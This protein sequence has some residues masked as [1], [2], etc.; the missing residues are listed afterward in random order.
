MKIE[1]RIKEKLGDFQRLRHGVVKEIAS[2][3]KIHRHTI[4]R[5]CRNE[6]RVVSFETLEK[7]CDWFHEIGVPRD[8]L[9]GGLLGFRR[10]ALWEAIASPGRV[11]LYLGEYWEEKPA[12]A[13]WRWVARRDS[14]VHGQMVKWLSTEGDSEIKVPEIGSVYVPFRYGSGKVRA[15]RKQLEQ[16]VD[17]ART[18][19][20]E[21][22]QGGQY[23]NILIGSQRANY[24]VELLVADL[25]GCEPFKPASGKTPFYTVYRE[26]DRLVPS[27]FGGRRLPGRSGSVAPGLYVRAEDHTWHAHPCVEDQKDAGLVITVYDPGTGSLDLV[28]LGFSG[29][30]TEAIGA[31]LVD[32]PDA[33]WSVEPD[34]KARTND[35]M[36][37]GVNVVTVTQQPEKT[38]DGNGEHR[39]TKAVVTELPKAVLEHYLK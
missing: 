26:T 24:L 30:S 10:S 32:K 28:V 39:R 2:E 34:G 29:R 5:L 1:F 19:F 36:E 17:H 11:T 3:S 21:M 12:A 14:S 37:V 8:Q 7:L 22:R 9:L 33:F 4:A 38:E 31:K 18:I 35:A 16:D 25:F 13:A 15:K 23:S 6:V 27:C 20:E